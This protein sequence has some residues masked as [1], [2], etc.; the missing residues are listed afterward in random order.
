MKTK[1]ISV[2][3]QIEGQRYRESHGMYYEDFD[4][5]DIYE[6][7][8]GR[9]VTEVDNIWQSLINLNRHP[10]H[11]DAEYA[12]DTEFGQPLVSSLVTFA[13][14]GGLSLGATSAR[15]IAN[16]GWRNVTISAPVFVGDTLYAETT[17]LEKRLSKSRPG[18]GIVTVE[19]RGYK[20]DGQLCMTKERLFL[21]PCRGIAEGE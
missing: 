7:R 16:L 20:Q 14:I 2:L 19:T 10:L 15:G 5:G 11:I 1:N 9:T 12:R 4:I 13:I 18:Q 3:E 8:P 6:H 21:I 17:V